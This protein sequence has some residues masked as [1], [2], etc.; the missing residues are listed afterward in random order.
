M[1]EAV[2][3]MLH[4]FDAFTENN[5]QYIDVVN[6][7]RICG[8]GV[9]PGISH[10]RR[11]HINPCRGGNCNSAYKINN[12][13]RQDKNNRRNALEAE[14]VGGDK[15]CGARDTK[16]INGVYGKVRNL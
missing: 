10:N 4:Q 6:N 5:S 13:P 1:T 15:A 2:K 9:W 3:R 14:Y 12:K 11:Y 8:Y 16:R 7:K